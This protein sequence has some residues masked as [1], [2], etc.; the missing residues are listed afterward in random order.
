MFCGAS[1]IAGVAAACSSSSAP[2]T[3]TTGDASDVVDATGLSAT[4]PKTVPDAGAVCSQPEGTT[5]AFGLC[6]GVYA[7]CTG[8]AWRSAP[9]TP[10]PSGCPEGV[11]SAGSTCPECFSADASC[12]YLQACAMDASAVRARCVVQSWQLASETCPVDEAGTDA[13]GAAN[14]ATTDAAGD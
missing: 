6:D 2:D 1:A 13:A 3:V 7:V 5:C 8:G 11:P 9:V 14:D 10:V 4:C 12:L